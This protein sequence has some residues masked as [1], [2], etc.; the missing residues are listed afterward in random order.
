MVGVGHWSLG[1]W[2]RLASEGVIE[3]PRTKTTA[4]SG[5]RQSIVMYQGGQTREE[6]C[7]GGHIQ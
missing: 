6:R 5:G 1:E 4:R 3:R 2:Y 7:Q